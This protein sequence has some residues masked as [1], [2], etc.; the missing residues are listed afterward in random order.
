MVF[1]LLSQKHGVCVVVD[2]E[3]KITAAIKLGTS[4]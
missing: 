1:C 2:S 3:G 4:I